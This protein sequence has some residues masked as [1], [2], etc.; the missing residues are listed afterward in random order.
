MKKILIGVGLLAVAGVGVLLY[1]NTQAKET[2]GTTVELYQ[3]AKQTPLHLKGQVQ[4]TNQ[5]TVLIDGEKGPIQT[6]HVKEGDHVV[7]DAALATYRWGEVIRATNDSVVTSLNEDAKNDPQQALMVLKS[8]ESAIKGTVTEYDREKVTLNEPVEIQYVNNGKKVT[9][10]ITNVAE[11]NNEPDKEAKTNLVTYNFTA[12]P[13]A[14]IPVG[15]SVEVLI[16]RNEIHLPLKSVGE[17]DGEHFVYTVAKNK[18]EKQL[19]TVEKDNGYYRLNGGLDEQAKIVKDVK[20][21]KDGMDVT[22][23]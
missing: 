21:L 9:G 2:A 23:E 14:A 22:V 4:S 3:V 16:P 11:M 18:T 13:D 1:Q 7:K 15:Y 17:K 8:E 20:G 19:V 10:K 6:I 12:I 5:Q